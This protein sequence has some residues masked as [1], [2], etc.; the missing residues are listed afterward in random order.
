VPDL[1]KT[2]SI[3]SAMFY[4]LVE[5]GDECQGGATPP[6][7]NDG[8]DIGCVKETTWEE[9]LTEASDRGGNRVCTRVSRLDDV[10]VNVKHAGL[11]MELVEAARSYVLSA[12]TAGGVDGRKL[13]RKFGQNL[14]RG[15][16]IAR[17][18]KPDGSGD[19]HIVF[20]NVEFLTG[21]GGG[22]ADD[23]F[24]ES[25]FGG[26]GDP[27]LYDPCEDAYW[28]IEHENAVVDIPDAFPGT[29]DY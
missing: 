7:Y 2:H 21:P 5:E 24:F 4:E 1:V 3:D 10:T 19:L 13:V 25:N 28:F 11:N 18:P 22:F 23:A 16:I 20:P 17:A 9:N 15:A 6:E 12:F 29:S 27:S 26:R 8:I 14:V